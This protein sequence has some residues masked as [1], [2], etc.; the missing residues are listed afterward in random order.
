MKKRFIVQ[1]C[2]LSFLSLF[3]AFE[4][5]S[6]QDATAGLIAQMQKSLNERNIPAYLENFEK[7]LRADEEASIKMKFDQFLMDSVT[8]YKAGRLGETADKTKIFLQA[9]FQ[10]SFSVMIENWRLSLVQADGRWMVSKKDMVGSVSTLYKIKIPSERVERVKSIEIE[11]VDAKLIFKDALVFFDNIPEMETALLIVGK[12]H[13]TFTPSD[14]E[15]RHQLD[16][17]YKKTSLEDELSYAY[18]RFSDYFFQNNIRI[19]KGKDDRQLSDLQKNNAYSLFSRHYP[20]SFTV[21]YSLNKE[22]YSTLPRGEEVAIDFNGKKYGNLTYIYTPFSNEEIH[23]YRWKDE[24]IINLYSPFVKDEKKRMFVTF[25]EMSDVTNYNIDIDFNPT[26]SFLSGKAEIEIAPKVDS[27]ERVK[28]KLNSKLEILHIYDQEMHELFYSRDKLRELLYI[29]FINP[30]SRDKP[31]TIEVFYRGK[32]SPAEQVENSLSLYQKQTQSLI[33]IPPKFETYLFTRRSFWYPSPTDFDYFTARLRIIVPPGY[34]CVSN[35]EL[36]DQSKLERAERVEEVDKVGSSIYVFETKYPLKY[37]SF[38]V[39]DIAKVKENSDSLLLQLY[40]SSKVY[41]QRKGLVEDAKR[42]I[43]F[44]ESKFGP[45]PYEKLG[46]VQRNWSSG[47]GHSSPSFIVL[48][49]LPQLAE[50]MQYVNMPS[51][52]DLSRWKEYFIAHEIAHQWWGQ[53]VTWKTY[54][55]QWLSEGLAQFAAALYLRESH[56]EDAY[57]SILKRFSLWTERYSKWGPITLGSRL[58]L[59]NFNAYQSIVYAKASLALNMLKDFLGDEVFFEGLKEFFQKYK[60]DAASTQDFQ[61]IMEHVSGKDLTVFFEQWFSSYLLPELK[62]THSVKKEKDGSVL[63]V[64][65]TQLKE[66]FV[67]PLWIEWM[68]KGE[69]VKKVLIVDDKTKIFEFKLG[70]KP[71]KIK[72]NPDKALPGKIL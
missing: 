53:A 42:I 23:L 6:Q 31:C 38:I 15:E 63:E 10:N 26:Q 5:R 9:L 46:I 18:L 24:R 3:L 62:V 70:E 44:Y 65:V 29:Y 7:E 45:F 16:L 30:P 40:C 61:R 59:F 56:G 28:L 1:A 36:I 34:S 71:K 25:G 60:Y 49:E 72:V 55:D 43:Q 13:V 2:A 54:H 58:S 17:I 50:G 37:L 41:F 11:H 20:N 32:I 35:G 47:G 48:N 27:L 67:F 21:E 12:G 14:P 4:A 39:G 19:E 57:S 66:Q 68:E 22:L 8:L 52:V 69:K 64:K 33:F 51:A